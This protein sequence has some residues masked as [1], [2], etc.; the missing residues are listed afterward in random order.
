MDEMPDGLGNTREVE[1]IV[2]IKNVGNGPERISGL[3]FLG[4]I[5]NPDNRDEGEIG[6]FDPENGGTIY[7][8]LSLQG[9]QERTIFSTTLPFFFE[10]DG[11]DCS[12]ESQ[13]GEMIVEIRGEVTGW[14]SV[15]YSVKYTAGDSYDDCDIAIEGAE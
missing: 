5:P 13:E 12:S 10:G 11:I 7:D 9:N 4:D 3:Q 8:P 1:A 2:D 15:D 14:T 6:I